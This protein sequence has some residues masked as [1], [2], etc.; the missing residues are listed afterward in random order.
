M[1]FTRAEF[2]ILGNEEQTEEKNKIKMWESHVTVNG[3][4]V[5]WVIGLGGGAECWA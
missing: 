3:W 4:H 5:G 2:V 1:G